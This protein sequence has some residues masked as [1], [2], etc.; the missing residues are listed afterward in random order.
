MCAVR[1]AVV[2]VAD[3][4]VPVVAFQISA[5][6]DPAVDVADLEVLLVRI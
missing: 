2:G 5:G 4:D 3:V 1:A 6:V